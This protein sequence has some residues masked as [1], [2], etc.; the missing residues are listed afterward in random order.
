[1]PSP[2]L[3]MRDRQ[4]RDS[5][6]Q[7][8]DEAWRSTIMSGDIASMFIAV[9][10][11]VSPFS[12][13]DDGD[14][15][16]QRVGAQPLLGNLERRARPRARLVEQ[17]DDGLAAQRRHFL[18][19]PLADLAHRFGG[20]EDRGRSRRATDRR[21]RADPSSFLDLHFVA[22]VGLRQVHLHALR[23]RRR[24]VLADVVGL[25]RQL[26]VAAVDQHDELNRLR[27]AELD[28][29]VERRANRP[30]GVEHVV[31]QQDPLV[32]DRERNLGAADDRLR[33]DG[34]AHQVVAIE[35]DV[36]RAGRHVVRG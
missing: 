2:A 21:C 25:D 13:L 31:D 32:V 20:V 30:A 22:A 17:V 15:D 7:A 18:D 16:V 24:Q 12:T 36:E 29:R 10:A 5:R 26:A 14:G 11:S 34:V 19:R 4:M 1:M 33:A 9:S 6:W 23:Q 27:P 35:R 28:Q 3:M 8:P